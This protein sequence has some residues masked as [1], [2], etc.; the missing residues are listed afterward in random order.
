M[1]LAPLELCAISLV[2]GIA[3]GLL[4]FSLIVLAVAP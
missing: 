3:A 2:A 1:K 4:V